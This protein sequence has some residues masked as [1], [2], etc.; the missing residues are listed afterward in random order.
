MSRN[1]LIVDDSKAVREVLKSTLVEA[2]Y[3][4]CDADDGQEAL[5]LVSDRDYDLLLTDLNMPE[6]GGLDFIS[7]VRK[8]PG[9]RFLPIVVFSSE[10]K[11]E[12]FVEC[13]KAGASGYLKKPLEKEQVLAI[14]DTVIPY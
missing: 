11:Q 8:I 1:I 4:V 9:R 5:D 3:N 10:D 14:L 6:M 2:G 12:R 7:E 13:L